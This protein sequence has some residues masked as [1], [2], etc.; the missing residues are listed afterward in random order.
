[1]TIDVQTPPEFPEKYREAIVRAI[2]QC[3]VK[4]HLVEPPAIDIRVA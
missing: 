4:R 1:L 3:T 2:D